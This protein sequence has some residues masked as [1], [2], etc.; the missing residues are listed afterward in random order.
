TPVG[1]A[2]HPRPQDRTPCVGSVASRLRPAR[3]S[4][5]SYVWLQTLDGD[6]RPCSLTGG[7]LGPGHAPLLVGKGADNAAAPQF[8]LSA[9]D[10]PPDVTPHRTADRH[11]LL[12]GLENA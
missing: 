11:Q 5:P 4:L 8:R 6:V 10:P 1:L 3:G 2:G 9:F 12:A 7:S